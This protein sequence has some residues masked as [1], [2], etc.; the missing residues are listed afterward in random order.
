MEMHDVVVVTSVKNID[1]EDGWQM[2]R[3][4]VLMWLE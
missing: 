3:M 1:K 4:H 2:E